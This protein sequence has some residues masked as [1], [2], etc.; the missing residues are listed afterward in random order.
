[1]GEQPEGTAAHAAHGGDQPPSAAAD[2]RDHAEAPAPVRGLAREAHGPARERLHAAG[3]RAR[4][5]ARE[6][7]DSAREAAGAAR[8]RLEAER[9][10]RGRHGDVAWARSLPVR[11]VRSAVQR[12]LLIPTLSFISPVNVVGRRNLRLITG[13]AVFVANHQSHLDAPVCLRAVGSRIRR[14]MVIAAAADYFYRWV[15]TGAAASIALGTVP[16]HRSG[17]QS[18]AS[19][20]L[21]KDLVGQG[22]HVLIFPSGTRG[23]SSVSGFK[24][25]FAYIAIDCQVPV[26]PLYLHGLEH[27]MPKGARIPLPGGVAVGVGSPIP[28]GDDYDDLV[29]RAELAMQELQAVVKRWEAA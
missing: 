27:V 12:G 18:R 21:L 2:G 13:P 1:M 15:V 19:L 17:G 24:K 7:A 23:A 20:E 11:L 4:D 8:H 25:G 5:R 9:Q 22:W 10:R 14:R 28:P 26:V 29:R 3:E 6:A 16:F